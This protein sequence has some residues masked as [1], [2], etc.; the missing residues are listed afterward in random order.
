MITIEKTSV[1]EQFKSWFGYGTSPTSFEEDTPSF[2]K[3]KELLKEQPLKIKEM[4]GER[5]EEKFSPT[6]M[7]MYTIEQVLIAPFPTKVCICKQ[8]WI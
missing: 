4:Y 6:E 1:P 7:G 5:L 2:L 3:L 8:F